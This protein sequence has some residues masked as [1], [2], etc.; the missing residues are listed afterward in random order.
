MSMPSNA[1]HRLM[2]A[3]SNVP[4]MIEH[5]SSSIANANLNILD[6]LNRSRNDIACTLVD[7]NNPIP[8]SVLDN[9]QVT[10][11]VLMVRI[12]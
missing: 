1:G 3:H 6:M 4:H 9:L 12:L 2:V 10:K 7:V 8:Q 11:D 5:I